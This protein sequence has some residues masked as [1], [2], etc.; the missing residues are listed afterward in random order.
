MES[1]QSQRTSLILFIQVLC[2]KDY[3]IGTDKNHS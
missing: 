3:F 1:I 2:A